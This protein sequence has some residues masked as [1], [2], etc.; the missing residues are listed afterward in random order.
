[1]LGGCAA[2][3]LL[4][5]HWIPDRG[6]TGDGEAK[7]AGVSGAGV[8]VLLG[9]AGVFV[10]YVACVGVWS[11]L[12]LIGNAAAVADDDVVLAIT[13]ALLV[14]GLGALAA[15]VLGQRIPQRVAIG[16]GAIGLVIAFLGLHAGEGYAGYLISTIGMNAA[17]NFSVSYQMGLVAVLDTTGRFT[18]LVTAVQGLGG[19]LGPALASWGRSPPP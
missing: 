6:R 4:L 13:L 7:D 2:T 10:F 1:M 8:G 9:L 12:E 15:A 19:V 18:V 11:F 3:P 16:I 14:G 5:V 17:W